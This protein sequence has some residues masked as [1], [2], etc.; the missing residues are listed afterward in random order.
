MI[1]TESIPALA[2]FRRNHKD[3]FEA[4]EDGFSKA[5]HFM[6]F[7][8]RLLC[9]LTFFEDGTRMLLSPMEQVNFITIHI[10]G[11]GVL[12][13]LFA[14]LFVLFSLVSQLVG[15][16]LVLANKKTTVGASLLGAFLFISLFLYGLA[17]PEWVHANGSDFY[18]IRL[19][20]QASAL[21][22]LAAEEQAVTT[23]AK[24]HSLAGLP[25]LADPLLWTH[26]L[27]LLGRCMMI[28]LSLAIFR[29][30]LAA[31]LLTAVMGIAVA[32][33]FKTKLA[34]TLIATIFAG[35]MFLTHDWEPHTT[36]DTVFYVL[37]QDLSILGGCLVLL[38]NGPGAYSMDKR[39]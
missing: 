34:T 6:P 4:I 37:C 28:V 8:A 18:I 5:S 21:M 1:P 35:S 12:S 27:Q 24:Q 11:Y 25:T 26:R 30:S 2:S 14:V 32:A 16:T 36:W 3:T 9:C 13:S 22:M 10:T 15:A 38:Q 29:H 33:G 19:L 31:G 7:L 20:G 23:R 17:A 39:K